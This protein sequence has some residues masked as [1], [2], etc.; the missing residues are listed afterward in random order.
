MQSQ[1]ERVNFDPNDIKIPEFF[2]LELHIHDYI[3]K[4]YTSANFHFNL[5]SRGFSPGR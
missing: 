3:L 5:F 4:F 2:Q 1:W